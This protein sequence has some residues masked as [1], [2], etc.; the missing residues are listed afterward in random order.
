MKVPSLTAITLDITQRVAW[1]TLNRPPLNI[2]TLD[3]IRE[4]DSAISEVAGQ[5]NL[6]ALVL[7]FERKSFLCRCGCCGPHT[8]QG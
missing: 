6:K 8:R 3:I 2:L 5:T 4:L 7:C 1:I